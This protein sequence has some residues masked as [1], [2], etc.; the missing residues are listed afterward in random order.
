MAVKEGFTM[1]KSY[2]KLLEKEKL[3]ISKL[4]ESRKELERIEKILYQ[5]KEFILKKLIIYLKKELNFE[6][7]RY[8]VVD[9]NNNIVD[10]LVKNNSQIFKEKI[11]GN[12]FLEFDIEELIDSRKY[13]NKDEIL[14]ID[15]GLKEELINLRYVCDSLKY[16]NLSYSDTI[17]EKMT[18]F[19]DYVINKNMN[20]N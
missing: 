16:E 3:I 17:K 2:E 9:I 13:N 11:E 8:R 6:Y 4:E 5:N 10:L 19:L 12:D 7:F 15:I 1:V 18:K 14:I 20:N